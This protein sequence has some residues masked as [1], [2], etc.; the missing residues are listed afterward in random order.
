MRTI[1]VGPDLS[2]NEDLVVAL[3][4]FPDI[5]LV[6][7]VAHYPEPDDLL[8]IIRA[9][10]PDFVFISAEDFERFQALAAAVDDRMP[11][12]PV[13]SVARG[14]NPVELIPKLMHLG[15]RELLTSPVNHEKLAE[16]IASIARQIARHPAP[17]VRMGDLYAFLPAKPG[18]GS[19]TIAVST[20]CAL[21]DEL[22]INTLLLDCDLM[23]GVTKF[24][25][26]LGNSSSIVN[27]LEHA[28]SLDEDMWTQMVGHWDGLHVLHA[29]ELAPPA[30]LTAAGL[31]V[32][33]GFARAQYDTICA[34]LASSLDPFTVQIMHEARR[35]FLVT[36]PELVP[37]YLTADRLRHLKELGLADKVSL[38]LNRKNPAHNGLSNAEVAQLAGLPVAYQFCN[39]YPG[40]QGAILDG[41]PVS[42]R[43]GLGQSIMTLARSIA[44]SLSQPHAPIHQRKF[45]Q[46]FHVPSARDSETVWQD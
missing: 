41:V 7:T 42:H 1:L 11:G 46:F 28:D 23:A 25:L 17:V 32:V 35:I 4:E 30:T 5:E 9:Q 8:R 27:A 34:D 39:D 3:A 29:G 15:I 38:L 44:P 24:L 14:R 40:V 18:V 33:L 13:I 36:T 20:S 2:A 26:K 22:H 12:L 10:R 19:S 31:E 6:R 21:A 43:S 45:L 37:L 16:S